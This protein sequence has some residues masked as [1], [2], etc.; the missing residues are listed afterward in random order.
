[1]LARRRFQCLRESKI[2]RSELA[3]AG[4]AEFNVI[5]ETEKKRQ[6]LWFSCIPDVRKMGELQRVFLYYTAPKGRYEISGDDSS[7]LT[8]DGGKYVKFCHSIPGLLG[9]EFNIG[10][11]Q[12]VFDKYAVKRTLDY[13][14]FISV[15]KEIADNRLNKVKTF[16]RFKGNDARFIKLS[17]EVVYG[18]SSVKGIIERMLVQDMY[19]G[20]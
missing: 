4:Q 1:M 16:G 17:L 11:A 14:G 3:A 7:P 15:M 8:M 10:R 18:A 2:R 19:P 13:L 6:I 12:I 20:R 5:F 9:N